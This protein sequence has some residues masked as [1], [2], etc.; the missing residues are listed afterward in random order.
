MAAPAKIPLS[1]TAV[2]ARFRNG[3]ILEECLA[4]L[5][6]NQIPYRIETTA[7]VF[8]VTSIGSAGANHEAILLVESS[9]L[10]NARQV[11]L[12]DARATIK[13]VPPEADDYLATLHT[14]DLQRML[15]EPEGWSFHDLAAAETILQQRGA[16]VPPIPYREQNAP[17]KNYPPVRVKLPLVV[18]GGLVTGGIYGIIIA[19]SLIFSRQHGSDSPHHYDEFSRRVGWGI[20]ILTLLAWSVSVSL[21]WDTIIT[22]PIGPGGSHRFLHLD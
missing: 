10:G 14:P 4:V 18:F 2:L 16:E 17:P 11:L 21:I 3:G 1:K 12:E 15:Q 6:Q 20:L 19:L 8:E 9:Q 5:A 13:L 7:P 22:P